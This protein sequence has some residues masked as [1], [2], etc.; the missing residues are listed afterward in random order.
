MGCEDFPYSLSE[1]RWDRVPY[2]T[3]LLFDGSR[4][5][6]VLGKGLQPFDLLD[7][8]YAVAPM[9]WP[10]CCSSAGLECAMYRHVGLS[11]K[12]NDQYRLRHLNKGRW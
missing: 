1:Q 12:R 9:V 8:Q 6:V 5:E 2:L 4:E 11:F 7:P 3:P 10:L